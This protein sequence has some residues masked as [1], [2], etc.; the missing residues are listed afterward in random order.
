MNTSCAK[1]DSGV[2]VV[3]VIGFSLSSRL[4]SLVIIEEKEGKEIR[5]CRRNPALATSYH[6]HRVHRSPF[7]KRVIQEC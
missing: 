2:Y 3:I 7:D 1:I 5:G 6:T 4:S